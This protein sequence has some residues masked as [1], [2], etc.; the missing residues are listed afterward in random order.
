[1][2]QVNSN[3]TVKIKGIFRGVLVDF[4]TFLWNNR[5]VMNKPRY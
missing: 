5:T 4:T 3:S 1:M 2:K